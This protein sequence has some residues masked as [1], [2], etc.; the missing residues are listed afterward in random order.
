VLYAF[1]LGFACRKSFRLPLS[2]PH[3][4]SLVCG[5]IRAT[6]KLKVLIKNGAQHIYNPRGGG[7]DSFQIALK[8][9]L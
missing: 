9:S 6:T 7:R 2:K 3:T 8:I 4:L 5:K 1:E